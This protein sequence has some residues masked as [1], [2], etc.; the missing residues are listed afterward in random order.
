VYRISADG[1]PMVLP[2]VG[3]ITYNIR[4][5]DLASRARHTYGR[6]Y[7]Q[8]AISVGI[9]VHTNRVIAGHGP[10]VTTLFTPLTGKIMSKIDKKANIASIIKLR[11]DI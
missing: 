1:K 10:G 11:K 8:G 6:I 7:K 9:V 5:G 2:S 4:V 3:G